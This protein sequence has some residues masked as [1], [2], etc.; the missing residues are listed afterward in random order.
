MKTIQ[1]PLS[2]GFLRHET[3][4]GACDRDRRIDPARSEGRLGSPS[5]SWGSWRD[6]PIARSVR[7][8][9]HRTPGLAS[10]L[11]VLTVLGLDLDGVTHEYLAGSRD[12]L[13]FVTRAD[14]YKAGVLAGILERAPSG[15]V[16]FRY[17]PEYTGGP[18]A[19][20]LPITDRPV[21]RPGGGLAPVLRRPPPE[22]HRL[23]VLRREAKTSSDDELT[24]LLAVGADAPGDVQIVP[25]DQPACRTRLSRRRRPRSTG[26]PAAHRTPRTAT[27][28]PACRPRH[29]PRCSPPPSRRTRERALLKI[30]PPQYPHLVANEVLHLGGGAR[31]RR[32]P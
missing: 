22:G 18:V 5:S 14:V 17:R 2:E 1:D 31:A 26:L 21:T 23:T 4:R 10:V 12:S 32:S 6:S 24:L 30:D 27:R 3:D 9:R 13:R 19:T 7:S 11:T 8:N 20:T 16:T 28:S 25:A 15:E 29:R